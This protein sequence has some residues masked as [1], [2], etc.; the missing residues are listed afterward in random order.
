MAD[1]I[2]FPTTN[3]GLASEM[4][5]LVDDYQEKRTSQTEMF[6]TLDAWKK[7]C[8]F[9]LQSDGSLAAG[10]SRLI[11]KRRTIVVNKALGF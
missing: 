6:E 7:N 5:R 9:M 3:K 8:D 2:L 1:Y 4:A 11:G 10:V